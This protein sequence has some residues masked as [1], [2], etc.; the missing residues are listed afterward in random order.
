MKIKN[1]QGIICFVIFFLFANQVWAAD[2]KMVGSSNT[3]K[4]YYDVSSIKRINKNIISVWTKR[5]YNEDGKKRNF[6][7]SKAEMKHQSIL[8]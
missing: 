3:A 8:P 5:I 4:E 7:F 6:L 2:W 1:L